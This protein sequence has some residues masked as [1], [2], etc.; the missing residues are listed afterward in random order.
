MSDKKNERSEMVEKFDH[1]C[2][3]VLK[4]GEEVI[5]PVSGEK[6]RV[7][8]RAAMMNVIRQRIKDIGVG[9]MSGTDSMSDQLVQEAAR[10]GLKFDGKDVPMPPLDTES[11]DAATG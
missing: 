5:N 9:S 10:R 8:P 2:I 7:K 1:L 4:K 3:E 11:E 6:E